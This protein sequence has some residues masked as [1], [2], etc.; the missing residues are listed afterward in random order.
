MQLSSVQHRVFKE[1]SHQLVRLVGARFHE[2]HQQLRE[3]RQVVGVVEVAVEV[4][5]ALAA[6][7]KPMIDILGRMNAWIILRGPTEM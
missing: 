5:I 1:A 4:S 3:L 7:V 6:K 2:L